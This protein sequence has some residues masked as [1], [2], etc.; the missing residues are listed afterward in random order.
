MPNK[1]NEMTG[2]T[3]LFDTSQKGSLRTLQSRNQPYSK[4]NKDPGHHRELNVVVKTTSMS[5]PLKQL[6]SKT[7]T[8]VYENNNNAQSALMY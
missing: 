5:K 2:E 1:Y 6:V 7:K 3:P 8:A 4:L